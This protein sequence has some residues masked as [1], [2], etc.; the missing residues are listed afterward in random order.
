MLVQVH[1][2]IADSLEQLPA[3]PMK[4][5]TPHERDGAATPGSRRGVQVYEMSDDAKSLGGRSN[6]QSSVRGDGDLPTPLERTPRMPA[7]RPSSMIVEGPLPSIKL[8]DAALQDDYRL[9]AA[10]SDFIEDP[11]DP[12]SASY[13]EIRS[14]A[15]GAP[16][17]ALKPKK[18]STTS[19][20]AILPLLIYSV[21]QANPSKLVSHTLFVQRFRADSLMRG[22]GE[23]CLCNLDAVKSFLMSCDIGT[24]GLGTDKILTWVLVYCLLWG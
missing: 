3:I 24:L 10:S 8:P 6:R 22:E 23:Y 16:T 13:F 7:S 14:E 17:G 18:A 4:A 15:S 9:P 11:S 12:A 19:A 2:I 21:V 5:D 20:D 1:K